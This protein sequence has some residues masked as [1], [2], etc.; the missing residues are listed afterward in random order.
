MLFVTGNGRGWAGLPDRGAFSRVVGERIKPM[1]RPRASISDARVR[2][3]IQK[4][5]KVACTATWRKLTMVHCVQSTGAV[6]YMRDENFDS[7]PRLQTKQR[8]RKRKTS[9]EY[10]QSRGYR[11]RRLHSNRICLLH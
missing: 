5:G 10:V 7:F 8:S 2:I 1:K 3:S 4:R 6:E 9:E 11:K